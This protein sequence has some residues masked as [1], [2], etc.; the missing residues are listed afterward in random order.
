MA[1][2]RAA[3]LRYDIPDV[4]DL[5]VRRDEICPG[6]GGAQIRF[7]VYLPAPSREG[8]PPVVLFV[9]GDGPPELLAGA[10]DWPQYTGWGRLM[11][12]S[13]MAAVT[14]NRRSTEAFTR[15]AEA[16]AEVA[17]MLKHVQRSAARYGFEATRLGIWVCSAGPPTVLPQVLRSP[18]EGLRCI[19]VYYGLLDLQPASTDDASAPEVPDALL[20]Y[21]PAAA[22]RHVADHASV[23]PLLV[24]R[25]G[26]DHPAINE[27]LHRF[28]QTALERNVAIEVFNHPTG[29]HGFDTV[30]DSQR[31]TEAIERTIAFLHTH[32][33]VAA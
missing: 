13:G 16:E 22:L 21:S 7:D 3:T 10:K 32:L 26:R 8:L 11:A 6:L 25:A 2:P 19:V 29:E 5:V 9:H 1:D 20:R 30:T 33:H 27:N 28:V 23:P 31:T 4:P 18:P 12:A 15:M 24:V 17:T 14:F